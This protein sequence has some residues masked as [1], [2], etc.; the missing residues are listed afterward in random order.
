MF[1]RLQNDQLEG[2]HRQSAVWVARTCAVYVMQ[3][4]KCVSFYS[5]Q[6]HSV[7]KALSPVPHKDEP[8]SRFDHY[9]MLFFRNNAQIVHGKYTDSR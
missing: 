8:T 4:L 2:T 6:L 9:T 1:N 5:R 7:S 3:V